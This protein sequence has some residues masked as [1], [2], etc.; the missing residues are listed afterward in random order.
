M[1]DSTNV[2][3][4]Q[5]VWVRDASAPRG[6]RYGRIISVDPP[7]SP[8]APAGGLTILLEGG[9]VLARPLSGRGV[10][11]DIVGAK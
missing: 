3:R 7:G 5:R 10:E 2:R 9:S 6:R 11:W 4:G 8:L 1:G